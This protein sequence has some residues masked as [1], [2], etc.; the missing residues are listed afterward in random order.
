MMP[1]RILHLLSL[2]INASALMVIKSGGLPQ[3]RFSCR[4]NGNLAFIHL[5]NYLTSAESWCFADMM[6]MLGMAMLERAENEN[7][8]T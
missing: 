4:R 3:S 2:I 1:C 6:A 8:L 5:I 7:M